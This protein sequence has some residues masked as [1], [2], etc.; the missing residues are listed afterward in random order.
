MGRDHFVQGRMAIKWGN[1]IN[2]HIATKSTI[3][4]NAEDWG[5]KLL[6]INWRFIL[7]L[8]DIR[9]KE[10]KG[11]NSEE[12]TLN[13]RQ[14]LIDEVIYLQQ[15]HQDLPFDLHLFINSDRANWSQ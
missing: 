8:W 10:V 11:S 3:N 13:L 1:I 6:K 12:Q 7:V 5:T 14:D 2:Q 9:N 4:H 15:Q